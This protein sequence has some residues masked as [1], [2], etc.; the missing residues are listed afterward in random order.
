[1]VDADLHQ[2]SQ[3]RLF[4]LPNRFGLATLLT[5][6]ALQAE[7]LLQTTETPGLSVLTSGPLP[8]NPAALLG[9]KRMHNILTQLRHQA[10]FIIFDIPPVNAAVDALL[11]ANEVD[12]V[13]LTLVAQ[14]TR[15]QDIERTLEAFR[16][17]DV[18]VIGTVMCDTSLQGTT[19]HFGFQE[20]PYPPEAPI[21]NG[22]IVS[23]QNGDGVTT[24]SSDHPATGQD[25]GSD[26]GATTNGALLPP[27]PPSLPANGPPPFM[28]KPPSTQ[29]IRRNPLTRR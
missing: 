23:Y 7:E 29:P 15:K 1:L 8:A 20:H 12:G 19:R 6:D 17:I 28:P 13:I 25:N 14:R 5:D 10:D 26:H 21:P 3:Q 4:A 11:L 27:Q 2:P 9:Q 16:R 24:N 18:E 22:Q